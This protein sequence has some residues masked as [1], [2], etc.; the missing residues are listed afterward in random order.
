[1]KGFS[2]SQ[3]GQQEKRRF[4]AR[5]SVGKAYE[6]IELESICEVTDIQGRDR[7]CPGKRRIVTTDGREVTALQEGEYELEVTCLHLWERP[8]V[9]TPTLAKEQR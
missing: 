5:D 1:M 6:L 8:S 7:L 3:H 9:E 2:V 4:V